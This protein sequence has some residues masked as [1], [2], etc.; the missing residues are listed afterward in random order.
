MRTRSALFLGLSACLLTLTTSAQAQQRANVGQQVQQQLLN[1]L[2]NRALGQPTNAYPNQGYGPYQNQVTRPYQVQRPVYGQ[3]GYQPPYGQGYGQ[4]GY[5]Q[6][7]P[8]LFGQQA[9]QRYQL[10]AQYNGQAPGSNLTYGGANYV[11]NRDGT[12][13]P[14]ARPAPVA[15]RYQIPARF[16]GAAPGSTITYG[17]AYYAIN[18]DGTMSPLVGAR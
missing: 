17:A 3:N 9:T 13:S 16:A 5:Q 10:P 12:M 11:V 2:T 7:R 18:S 8:G 4:P 1:N 15:Q 14:A 6:S